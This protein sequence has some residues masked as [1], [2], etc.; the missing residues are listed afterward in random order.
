VQRLYNTLGIVY[1]K[2]GNYQQSINYFQKALAPTY[3]QLTQPTNAQ[4]NLRVALR[5]AG[6]RY[7]KAISQREMAF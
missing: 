5:L 4:A 3:L 6:K 1:H 7:K 2:S